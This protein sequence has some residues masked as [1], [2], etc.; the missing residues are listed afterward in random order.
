M[1][2]EQVDTHTTGSRLAYENVGLSGL[3]AFDDGWPFPFRRRARQRSD[4]ITHGHQFLADTAN[5]LPVLAEDN[6]RRLI[7]SQNTLDS[8]EL[9]TTYLEDIAIIIEQVSS[10]DLLELSDLCDLQRCAH[11]QNAR[12]HITFE[13][14][15]QSPLKTSQRHF[16]LDIG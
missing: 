2:S 15:V 9:R 7:L 8:T 11:I 3:K 10:R 5:L 14:L 6:H 13:L 12:D 4:R 16:L 1:R